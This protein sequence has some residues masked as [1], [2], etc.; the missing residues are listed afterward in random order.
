MGLPRF[1]GILISN[2]P[3]P[4]GLYEFH[5]VSAHHLASAPAISGASLPASLR[6]SDRPMNSLMEL[7][8]AG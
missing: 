8:M 6:R 5:V 4:P 3:S 7:S 2:T 1:D